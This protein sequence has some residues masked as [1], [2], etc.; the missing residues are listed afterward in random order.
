MR[1]GG[2]GDASSSENNSPDCVSS[3]AA[4]LRFARGADRFVV[5]ARRPLLSDIDFDRVAVLLHPFAAAGRLRLAH[6][7]REYASHL[8]LAVVRDADGDDASRFR[9]HRRFAQLL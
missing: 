8:L 6:E 9:A 1:G 4:A 2:G 7:L 5:F 3:T